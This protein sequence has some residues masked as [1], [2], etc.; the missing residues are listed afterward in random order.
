MEEDS[1]NRDWKAVYNNH[2]AD[3]SYRA[4][5]SGYEI[6][7]FKALKHFITKVLDVGKVDK[8]LDYGAGRGLHVKLWETI[9][10]AAELCFA[11]ISEKALAKLKEDFA[12]YKE[13]CYLIND[14]RIEI[15]DNYF[16]V[17]VSVEVM[18]H[19]ANLET[20]LKEVYRLLKPGGFFIWTTPCANSFSIEHIYSSVTKQIESTGEGF[21]RWAWEDSDHLRRLK[22]KEIKNL[23]TACGFA[24]IKFRFRAHLFSFLCAESRFRKFIPKKEWCLLLDYTLW[25]LFS[26]GASMLGGA[27]KR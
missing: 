9:F 2:Y 7:R 22:S 6:A 14:D 13:S 1:S 23:L 4:S 27:V 24:D 5:L 16:S 12:E 25:R 17:V 21:R 15:E 3:D 20:Y 10:S 19:V 8:V 11:D 18:E 26:N